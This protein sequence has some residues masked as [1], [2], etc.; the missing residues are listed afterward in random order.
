[1]EVYLNHTSNKQSNLFLR[2]FCATLRKEFG[3]CAWNFSPYKD[4][5]RNYVCFGYV[6]IGI[7]ESIKVIVKYK[8]KGVIEK[9]VV[10]GTKVDDSIA[11]RLVSVIDSANNAQPADKHSLIARINIT[12]VF[13]NS[14]QKL[15]FENIAGEG[16]S[17]LSND[18]YSYLCIEF[19][20]FDY[21]DAIFVG[22]PKANSIR[23]FLAACT[24]TKLS[25]QPCKELPANVKHDFRDRTKLEEDWIDGVPIH[26]GTINISDNQANFISKI[27]AGT[28]NHT[29]L[30]A[31]A[32]FYN[33]QQSWSMSSINEHT[34]EVATV[35]YVSALEVAAELYGNETK[36]CSSCGQA[37][38]SIRR[39]V[40]D[41]VKLHMGDGSKY[42][43]DE[44]YQIRSK[45]LHAGV[46]LSRN[47]Y[48]G[49]VIPQLNPES[50]TG[51][52]PAVSQM[53]LNLME[54]VSYI[55]RKVLLDKR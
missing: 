15:F 43:I 55:L 37:K 27:V 41:L 1:M 23:D 28:A 25:L 50:N 39:R 9:V 51:C 35:L 30:K 6:D 34:L 24:N 11:K 53:P 21:H 8:I 22:L 5:Q 38:Y 33:A 12:T 29:Y 45:Y 48:S 13:G 19:L 49:S 10:Q 4:G 16:F 20:A 47:N 26:E 46:P 54:Y 36:T 17:I 31:C 2:A 40:L 14:E 32:H 44:F 18:E 7:S 42:L 52:Y 3:K